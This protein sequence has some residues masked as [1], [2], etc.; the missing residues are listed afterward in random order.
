[1]IK[2]LPFLLAVVVILFSCEAESFDSSIPTQE[3]NTEEVPPGDSNPEIT[4]P[5][6]G[7][8]IKE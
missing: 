1:M 5:N 8:T 3:N 7:T 6:D 4:N 2:K